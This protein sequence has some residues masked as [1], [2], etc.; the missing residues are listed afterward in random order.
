[1]ARG[2]AQRLN[3]TWTVI[4]IRRPKVRQGN[5]LGIR[6]DLQFYWGLSLF[7]AR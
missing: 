7:F 4:P 6:G 5:R 3:L 1:M 2:K